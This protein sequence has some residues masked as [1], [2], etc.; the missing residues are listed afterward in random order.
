MKKTFITISFLFSLSV[1]LIAQS[2]K[3]SIMGSVYNDMS[4]DIVEDAKVSLEIAG[5]NVKTSIS[6]DKGFFRIYNVQ[7]GYYDIVV[8]AMGFSPLKISGIP[9][10]ALE[11][12]ALELYF[13]GESYTQ[14][15]AFMSYEEI[16]IKKIGSKHHKKKKRKKKAKKEKKTTTQ[17]RQERAA[18]KLGN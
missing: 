10:K 4:G 1:L 16:S 18:R 6:D 2:N 3:G 8:S 12:T 17:K 9:V 15:T 11:N 7:E 5:A 14:D 13:H